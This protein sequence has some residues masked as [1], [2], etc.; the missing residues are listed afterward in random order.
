MGVAALVIGI[1]SMILGFIPF[2]GAIAFIPAIIGIILAIV[3]IVK[4]KKAGEKKG[5]A[6]AGLVLSIIAV[7]VISVWSFVI[8]AG[9]NQAAKELENYD[10]NT[11]SNEDV[12]LFFNS[13]FSE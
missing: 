13:L 9:V 12:Q 8:S 6:I 1:I 2:C 5:V 10:Y 4:K 3:D 11:L 7:V